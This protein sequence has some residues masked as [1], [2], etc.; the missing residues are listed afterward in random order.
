M[1][2]FLP[3]DIIDFILQYAIENPRVGASIP[4]LATISLYL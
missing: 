2:C 4:S 1:F 3:I